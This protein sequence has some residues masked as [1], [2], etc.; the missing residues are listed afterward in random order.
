MKSL[1]ILQDALTEYRRPV[2][3]ELAKY[4]SVTVMH[5]NKDGG[6]SSRNYAEFVIPQV[7]VGPFHLQNFVSI[8]KAQQHFD[9]VISMFDLR[10]P[11]YI[12]PFIGKRHAKWILWGHRYSANRLANKARDYLM[13]CADKI[14]LYGEEETA[15]MSERGV[16]LSTVVV[17][18]NTIHVP[19]HFD[20]S[21]SEK[22]SL[23]FV[24]RL[25]ERKRIDLIIRAF[26]QLH[27]HIGDHIFL[28]IV[29]GGVLERELRQ[30]ANELGVAEKINFHGAVRDHAVLVT[31]FSRAF[32]YISPGPVGLGVLHSFAYGVPV[33]TLREGRHGPEYVNLVHN[34]NAFILDHEN[35]LATAIALIC[36][37]LN[38]SRLLGHNAY[39]HYTQRRTLEHMVAGFI[40]AI[41][42]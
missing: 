38:F 23:L 33:I 35:D 16:D 8:Y 29:G 18:P 5:A 37:D 4:Y 11:A 40:K 24:G 20:T 25:Q 36:N 17:A 13:K 42:E 14:L 6:V 31:L 1:L 30:L 26:S 41:E 7:R 3:D 15:Q 34:H 9:A 28:D 27:G 12:L 39:I 2:L 10:W 22:R 32:A 19:N 21:N